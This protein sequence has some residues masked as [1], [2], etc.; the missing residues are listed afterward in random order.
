MVV[1]EAVSINRLTE[2]N[3]G[4]RSKQAFRLTT[5][6]ELVLLAL[7]ATLTCCTPSLKRMMMSKGF[8][9]RLILV[10]RGKSGRHT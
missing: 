6:D 8:T 9:D 2:A 1:L 4:R 10:E 5:W 7:R 3:L